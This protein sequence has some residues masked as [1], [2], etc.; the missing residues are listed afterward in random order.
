M[1]FT[2]LNTSFS[3][4]TRFEDIRLDKSKL[5][6]HYPLPKETKRAVNLIIKPYRDGYLYRLYN[7]NEKFCY[8]GLTITTVETFQ[9]TLER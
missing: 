4:L 2:E 6:K 3:R 8:I 7:D 5:K 1:D 9:T